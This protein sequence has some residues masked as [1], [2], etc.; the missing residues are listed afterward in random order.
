MVLPAAASR[1]EFF[2]LCLVLPLR[3]PVTFL[4]FFP[5]LEALSESLLLGGG[6]VRFCGGLA[7]AL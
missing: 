3:G 7:D 1:R 5:Q 6:L 2:P 4:A